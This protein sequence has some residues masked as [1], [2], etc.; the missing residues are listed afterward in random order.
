MKPVAPHPLT[1]GVVTIPRFPHVSSPRCAAFACLRTLS[2]LLAVAPV[3]AHELDVTR[4]SLEQLME[5]EV[6]S[7][8]KKPQPLTGIAAAITVI[9]RDDIH[10]SGA[11]NIPELL[12]QVPGVQ[13]ARIDASRYSVS[14]RGFSHRFASK[15][16][17]LLDGRTLYTPLFAGVYWE[18]QDVLLEEV[19]RI[20]IIRGPGGTVWGANAVNGVIN[21]ITRDSSKSAGSYVEAGLGNL[22][23]GLAAR[24]GSRLGEGGHF[25]VYGSYD[26]HVALQASEGDQ[27]HD[28]WYQGRAGF[29]SDHAL[30]GS[31]YL[32]I[33]GDVYDMRAEQIVGVSSPP[34]GFTAFVPDR[35]RLQGSN[36]SLR[37][38]HQLSPG[39]EWQLLTYFDRSRVDD[40]ILD[41]QIDIF[42][43]DFQYHGRFAGVHGLGAGLGYRYVTDR[44]DGSYTLSYASDRRDSDLYSLFVQDEI[45]MGEDVSLTLGS[46]FEWND[47]S[48]Y[49][50]QPG[51]RLLWQVLPSHSVW[52][53]LTRAVQTPSRTTRDARL[54]Y[55][56]V[57]ADVYSFQGNADFRSEELLAWELGYRGSPG[58]GL[59]LDLSGF[60]NQYKRLLT[61]RQDTAFV[62]T[63]DNLMQGHTYGMELTVNWN[64][65]EDWRLRGSYSYLQID[66]HTRS[67]ADP[68]TGE[69][70]EERSPEHM[71]CLQ[72]QYELN[73][74]THIDASVYYASELKALDI[75][76]ST[77]IDIGISWRPDANREFTL[78]A[79]NL[80]DNRHVEFRSQDIV[81]SE[82]PR[83]I[84]ARIRLN[85]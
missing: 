30:G 75:D 9:S 68:V 69:R 73:R 2:I 65:L 81:S 71:L 78:F 1:A 21:I 27:E 63:Y 57:G 38:Q 51:V 4:L 33:Q 5:I 60:Y 47:Y 36:L 40:A 76:A 79:Y 41:Q 48:G 39:Q 85:Y 31:D 83:S 72:P 10:R 15:L 20:E 32:T 23:R 74:N 29:R 35:A 11:S 7:P 64:P 25:R 14:I 61:L 66:L 26:A 8:A 37:W 46:K 12:R 84:Y 50:Y 28:A 82:I 24:Y 16:L 17:V 80:L 42:D 19:E 6:T 34:V 45:A 43:M 3:Q 22:Q 62:S 52:T 49:E 44:I 77:R 56:V 18:A 67:G 55:L 58:R 59:T 70:I 54:N 13:V 53:A